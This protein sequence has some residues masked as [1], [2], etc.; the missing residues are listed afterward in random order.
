MIVAKCV[1][2]TPVSVPHARCT[3]IAQ[4][5]RN[6]SHCTKRNIAREILEEAPVAIFVFERAS[7]HY[8]YRFH[9]NNERCVAC[10]VTK[11]TSLRHAFGTPSICPRQQ[12][13]AAGVSRATNSWLKYTIAPIITQGKCSQCFPSACMQAQGRLSTRIS[14][15]FRRASF[16]CCPFAVDTPGR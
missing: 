8:V 9:S 1:E 3:R 7:V 15:F 12:I 16:S 10:S 6:A 5:A 13:N 4:S 2:S 11:E 14:R